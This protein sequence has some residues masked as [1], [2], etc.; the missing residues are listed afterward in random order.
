VYLEI[1]GRFLTQSRQ[2]AKGFQVS[3][4]LHGGFTEM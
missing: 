1:Y 2:D 4:T 3:G